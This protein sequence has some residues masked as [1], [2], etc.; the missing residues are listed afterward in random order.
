MEI[1]GEKELY[2]R[3]GLNI[4]L[5]LQFYASILDS[6]V[7][8]ASRAGETGKVFKIKKFDC[9]SYRLNCR[10]MAISNNLQ[11]RSACAVLALNHVCCWSLPVYPGTSPFQNGLRGLDPLKSVITL[12]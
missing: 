2:P 7:I 11:N 5:A 8:V 10:S 9:Q 6:E 12:L 3:A 4:A 1:T